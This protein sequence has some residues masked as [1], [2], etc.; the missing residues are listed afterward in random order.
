MPEKNIIEA[1]EKKGIF[2]KIWL[3]LFLIL[4]SVGVIGVA[5]LFYNFKVVR[6]SDDIASK[7]L[8]NS[9]E[10]NTLESANKVLLDN[11][12]EA[13]RKIDKL[14]IKLTQV[15][16]AKLA[17]ESLPQLDLEKAPLNEAPVTPIE[18][19]PTETTGLL[20]NTPPPEAATEKVASELEKSKQNNL[21]KLILASVKLRDAVNSSKGFESELKELKFFAHDNEDLLQNIAVL[22]KYVRKGVLSSEDLLKSFDKTASEVISIANKSKKSGTFSDKVMARFG[23]VVQVRKVNAD[24]QSMRVDD[25]IA[26]TQ[27]YLLQSDIKNAVSELANLDFDAKNAAANWLEDARAYLDCK[28]ASEEIFF[29][30]SQLDATI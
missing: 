30:V 26:R 6:N 3:A 14:S 2:K 1:K 21:I 22:E 9:E 29:Y 20:Q 17:Q 15:E 25:I 24:A 23:S 28:A 12:Q 10:I 5:Y 13:N 19:I 4:F 8:E 16:E 11:L 7:S 18:A 27:N